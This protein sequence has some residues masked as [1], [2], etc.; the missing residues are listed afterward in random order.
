MEQVSLPSFASTTP[1]PTRTFLPAVAVQWS[2]IRSAPFDRH[3]TI[4]R[5]HKTKLLARNV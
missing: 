4:L 3:V 1:D 2:I 5:G